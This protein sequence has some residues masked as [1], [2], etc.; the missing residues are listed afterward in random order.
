MLYYIAK[1]I[2]RVLGWK[3]DKDIAL[4]LW[5]KKNVVIGF[6]HTSMIDTVVTMV[7]MH[8]LGKTSYTFIKQEMFFW[9][10]SWLLR[11]NNAV[12]VDRNASTGIVDQIVSQFNR[13]ETYSVNIV[14]QGTRASVSTM[15]TG[16]WH[17]AKNAKASVLCWYFDS[18]NRRCVC[19][20]KFHPG[21]SVEE[22]LVV[23]QAMY[24]RVGYKLPGIS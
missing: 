2:Y 24:D 21:N 5:E 10:L 17:I 7:G 9:P 15:R 1:G 11:L 14:P 23:M 12:P 3:I 20:G 13:H 19:L 22:D 18:D 6:P 4:N 16:F 8:L